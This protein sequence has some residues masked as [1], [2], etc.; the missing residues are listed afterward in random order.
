MME[1]SRRSADVAVEVESS[2]DGTVVQ[3]LPVLPEHRQVDTDFINSWMQCVR[4]TSWYV[5][6]VPYLTLTF[7]QVC[8]DT[9]LAFDASLKT[10]SV[11]PRN[12]AKLKVVSAR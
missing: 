5:R 6:V 1:C 8:Y 12:V 3:T 10:F 7:T 4:V 2:L 11:A 9:F